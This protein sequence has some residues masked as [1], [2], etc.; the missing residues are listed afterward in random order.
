MLL[1]DHVTS[2]G[3]AS[4]KITHRPTVPF[5]LSLRTFFYSFCFLFLF[6]VMFSFS[7]ILY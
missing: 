3:L 5:H 6:Y 2:S 7:F 4:V 1:A